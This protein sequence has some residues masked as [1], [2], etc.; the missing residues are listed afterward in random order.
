MLVVDTATPKLHGDTRF[1]VL[2]GLDGAGKST[3]SSLLGGVEGIVTVETPVYPLSR[4]KQE[5]L[6][7]A[8]P[9]ARFAYFMAGNMQV[10]Y[11]ADNSSFR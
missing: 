1:V 9:M 11:V 2:E 4:I 5:V 3:V 10:S 8:G 7:H 6:E